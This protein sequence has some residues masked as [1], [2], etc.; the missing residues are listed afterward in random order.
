MNS[1]VIPLSQLLVYG[2]DANDLIS[3]GA[4]GLRRRAD[5]ERDV[6]AL[7]HRLK[8][9]DGRRWLIA[10]GDA[11][12]I[13]VGVFG[14]LHAGGQAIL[15]ANLQAG[16]LA[17]TAAGADA[18]LTDGLN[19]PATGHNI[20]LFDPT[21]RVN[22]AG[23]GLSLAPIDAD[24]AEI[25]MHTSGTTGTPT[26]ICK[27]LRCFEAELTSQSEVFAPVPGTTVIATVPPYH[28]Y[29]LLFRI[30]WPLATNRPFSTDT[31]SYP[32]ELITAAEEHQGC[33]FVSSPAFLKRGS[34]WP[35]TSI[36]GTGTTALRFMSWTLFVINCV[37]VLSYTISTARFTNGPIDGTSL[38]LV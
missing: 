13:S 18:I 38:F 20:P 37:Q 6:A 8:Q 34:P 28:I 11:Y 5:F 33:M 35:C 21:G 10:D 31:V 29:G 19:I 36:M 17:D 27:P 3:T 26:S 14:A 22:P 15:P 30:L 25:V 32:E 4:A 2:G 9:E 16:H 7:A 23:D 12:A 24:T 1:P